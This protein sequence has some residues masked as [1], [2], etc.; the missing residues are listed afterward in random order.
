V[1]GPTGAGKTTFADLLIGL[2]KPDAGEITV[3]DTPLRGAAATA[4]RDHI[5]YVVQDPYLFRDTVRRN[6]LWAKP[7][8]SE[9]EIWDAVAVAGV[10]QF[11]AGL[12][13]GLE[14]V[15][16]E[17]GTLISGGERRRL[18]LA[19]AV[20]RRRW[21]F[22][23]DEATSAIDVATEGK[24]LK[25]IVNLNPRPTIVMIAHRD[26]T[27][28]YCDRMLRFRNGTFVAGEDAL[29]AQPAG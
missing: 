3:G 20:L 28:A 4:W 10:D 11:V 16:G 9:A 2:L 17:R 26:Q 25:R 1:S 5:G 19:R 21:L 27:L 8:A 13:L 29:A 18:C 14:T 12:E 6:L 7:Q 22:V 24:I 15:L 23:L